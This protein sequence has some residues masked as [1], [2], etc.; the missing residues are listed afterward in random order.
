MISIVGGLG[1]AV[2]WATATLLSSRSTRM[3]GSWSVLG[4][5]MV[6]GLAAGLPPAVA[7]APD[8]I[9]TAES[10]GLATLAGLGYVVG[11]GTAYRALQLGKVSVVAPILATEGA[12][13]A[14]FA[15]VLGEPLAAFAGVVLAVVAFGVVLSTLERRAG[16]DEPGPTADDRRATVLAVCSAVAFAFG[17]VTTGLVADLLPATWVATSARVVGVVLIS[18]PLLVTGRLRLSRRALPFVLVAGVC[19]LLGSIAW[20]IGGRESIPV[21]AVLGS[22]FAAIAVVVGYVAFGERLGR[23]QV[24]GV[25]IVLVGVSA[26]AWIQA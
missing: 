16:P 25:V 18:L 23:I 1:A 2:L 3:I 15:V 11:L 10:A 19:E 5:V 8:A 6:V 24:A 26:L 13:A 20:A 4:W 7:D 21:T 12:L 14:V 9:L 17:L 22:Q